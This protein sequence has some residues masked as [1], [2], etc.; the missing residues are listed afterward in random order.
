MTASGRKSLI[1]SLSAGGIA[2]AYALFAVLWVISSH[3]LMT[4]TVADP[5]LQS[6]IEIAKGLLFVSITSVL[7]YLLLKGWRTSMS[8]AICTP[9]EDIRPL[10]NSRL[11]LLFVAF[12]LVVPLIGLGVLK[13]YGPQIERDAYANLQTIADLKAKQIENWLDERNGDA[14]MLSTYKTFAAQVEKFVQRQ[15]EAGLSQPILERFANLRNAYN[16][17]SI[18]LFDSSGKLLL[19]LGLEADNTPALQQQIHQ[20]ISSKQ[21]QRG[22]LYRDE[23]GHVHQDWTV[24]IINTNS[25]QA[26]PSGA[27]V[28]RVTAQQFIFPLIQTWPT[29]SISAETMLV[30]RDGDTVSYLNELRQ[31]QNS[32][33]TLKLPLTSTQLPAAIAVTA[34]RPG[35]VR[36]IDYR[37]TEVLAAYRPVTGTSWHLI[38]KIDRDE[39]LAPLRLM[40]FLISVVVSFAVAV[41][42]ATVMMLWR[43]QQ[44]THTLELKNRSMAAIEESERRFRSVTESAGDAIISV[45][46]LGNIVNWNPC[47]ERMFG[48]TGA[49]IIGQQV[50]RLVPEHFRQRHQS[51]LAKLAAGGEPRILGRT[52]ELTG[53]HKNGGEFPLELSLAQWETSGGKF[54]TA[55][56][57]N[58]SERKWAEQKLADSER[59]FRSLFENMLEGYA[60]CRMIFEHGEPRD[61]I[62]LDVNQAFTTLTG[63][64]DVIGK[65]ISTVIPGIR[66]SD[67]ALLEVYGQVVQTGRPERFEIHVHALKIWLSISVYCPQPEHFVAVFDNITQRK[68]YE[69]KIQRL[70]QLYSALSQCNQA[71]VRCTDEAELFPQICLD[72]VQ[73]GGMKMA[74]V[75][76]LDEASRRVRPVASYGEGLAYLEG[77]EISVDG[78][79]PAGRGPIGIAIREG[80]LFWSQD[81]LNDPLTAPWHESGSHFGW[82]SS[83]SLPLYRD[84]VVIGAFSLYS[85]EMN[86]FDADAQKLLTEMS[87]DISYALNNFAREAQRK[88]IAQ[89]LNEKETR[90]RTLVETIPDLI[91]LKDM[92]GVYLSCNQMFERFV[93]KK[94]ADILGK[95]DYDFVDR[96]LADFSREHDR[97]AMAAGKPCINEEWV[98]FADDGHR[99]LLETIKTPMRDAGG[100]LIG[101]LGI[102]RDITE[103]RKAEEALRKLSQA[104]E[105]S[106]SSIVITDLEANIEYANAAFFKATGYRPAEA[107]GQNPKILHSGKTPRETYD[108]MWEH[109]TRG[110]VWKGEFINKRKDGSEYT[111]AVLI[112]PVRQADGKVTHYLA[113]KE[114]VTEFKRVQE[115]IYRLNEE[116]ENKVGLRT[117]ELAQTNADLARREEEIRSVVNTM[118]DC[119]ITI[120]DKGII[121]SANP[122]VEKIF[123]YTQDEVI[124]KNVSML[125]P[126]PDHSSHDSYLEHRLSTGQP[127]VV[128]VDRSVTG[129]HK[130]GEHIALELSV[131]EYF[132]QE[133][134]Y[135]TGIL[136]DIRERM[137]IM[138]DLEQARHNAEQASRAKSDFLAAMSHEIRTPMNGVIGMIDVLQQSSLTSQQMEMTSIIHDSAF[139]LLAVIDDILDFSKIEAGKLQI[140]NTTLNIAAVLEGVCETLDHMAAKKEVELTMYADPDIPEKVM[141]DPGRLRQI[142][143]NLVNN[144]IKFSSGQGRPACVSVRAMPDRSI[145]ATDAATLEFQVSDNGIGIDPATQSRLFTPF[146]QA[147]VSTT[148]TFGGTGLGLAISRHLV[149]VMGGE[150]S[151]QSK[152]G[153]G[154]TFRVRLPFAL[155]DARSNADKNPS[156]VSGLSCLVV[157]DSNNLADDMAAYLAHG[158]AKVARAQDNEKARQWL[159]NQPPGLCVV[160]VDT[161]SIASLPDELRAT[162]YNGKDVCLVAIGRGQRRRCRVRANGFVDLDANVMHRS[163]FL[164]AVSTA[165][166]RISESSRFAL[167]QGVNMASS[168]LSH[169]EARRRGQLILIA[170]DNEINQKVILKQLALLGQTAE[171]SSN[172]REALERWQSGDYSILLTDLH[173]PEM[174]GYELTSAIRAAEGGKS[175]IPIIAFTANALKDEAAHCRSIGM[176]DYLS[177]PVQLNNLRDMLKKWLPAGRPPAPKAEPMAQTIPIPV[178][179]NV[180]KALVGDDEAIV[181]EFLHDFR[182]SANSIAAELRTACA[183]GQTTMA[184]ALAH[185]LKSSARSVG[186]LTLGELCAAIEKAGKE[187]DGNA[188]TALLPRFEAELTSVDNHLDSL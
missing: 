158:G 28:L 81:F 133:K 152:V 102:A 13:L 21:I 186:A 64:K 97:K 159:Q 53:L 118:L 157:G 15:H 16:Y 30:R 87:M 2:L 91:W 170:E 107:L 130:N 115:A 86:A 77:I 48:Y 174:D 105:Q 125:M 73:F 60:Y 147:D 127:R 12:A 121:R 18:L 146:T 6:N 134:H 154:S 149:N 74:W 172:G 35:T 112:S 142:L 95:T 41:V 82:G 36:G 92:D 106:P 165:S 114:D 39:V 47:A 187:N 136:R 19:L 140:E 66:E 119:V 76:L 49:E 84:N 68:E 143:I 110:E 69:A 23:S 161:A 93:G 178:D 166:G 148:R 45:D 43:Q 183:S 3:F 160:V 128:G 104:V 108:D 20:A 132:V 4:S 181:R 22:D 173:M 96:E 156:P 185:K 25:P 67:P 1:S 103:R 171:I 116:L 24:P 10:Q 99:A 27:V 120:D 55:I 138:A 184:G 57:R 37:G 180:L 126:E 137:H 70:A 58:I 131:S 17:D 85:S 40:A 51:G 31:R 168:Q 46:S 7:L 98:T 150:I 78:N 141:G 164:E 83:A 54:F 38:A 33:L 155:P 71:I 65:T 42:S 122:A 169:D 101:V 59:H 94:E 175:R 8:N 11:V 113:I 34:A 177:K 117:A 56:I 50:I 75:G 135:F 52:M 145:A 90:L 109:L 100:K 29:A 176:D 88:Q 124:G 9:L 182:I 111:E 5:L 32:A 61:F 14:M 79:D 162:A 63:L 44:R 167:L 144:A 80:R 179:V 139:A 26:H 188:L 89:A 163:A 123:G 129:L 151:V 153:E 72:A 62:Y